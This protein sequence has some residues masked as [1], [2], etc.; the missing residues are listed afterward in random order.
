MAKAIGAFERKLMTP[1][2]WD[3]LLNGDQSALTPDEAIGLKTFLDTG[4]PACHSGALLGGT[5]YQKLGAGEGVPRPQ[6]LRAG[7]R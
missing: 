2:R 5:S 1:S 6:R 3:A 4:C 7:S